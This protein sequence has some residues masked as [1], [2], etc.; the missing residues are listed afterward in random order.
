MPLFAFTFH[1]YSSR[2][3]NSLAGIL[4]KAVPI[5]EHILASTGTH[6][7]K[8]AFQPRNCVRWRLLSRAGSAGAAPGHQ[9]EG[10]TAEGCRNQ[11]RGERRQ[12]TGWQKRG[13]NSPM[14]VALGGGGRYSPHH[15]MGLG[16]R[17]THRETGNINEDETQWVFSKSHS[18]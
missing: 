7:Q 16:T 13:G 11:G 10:A 3:E 2:A 15:G 12:K 18:P 6:S 8:S 9:A 1:E 5:S 14:V 17:P 4:A